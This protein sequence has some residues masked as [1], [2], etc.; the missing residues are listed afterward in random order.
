[1]PNGTTFSFLQDIMFLVA[2]SVFL[3]IV[4][5]LDWLDDRK[6]IRAANSPLQKLAKT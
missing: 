4:Y 1:M 3:D 2:V 5:W 6:G